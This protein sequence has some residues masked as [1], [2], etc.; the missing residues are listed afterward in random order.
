MISQDHTQEFEAALET[1]SSVLPITSAKL[2][3]LHLRFGPTAAYY[4]AQAIIWLKTRVDK[5]GLESLKT[6]TE[7][8]IAE[9]A[10]YRYV[11]KHQEA[12]DRFED[13]IQSFYI[14]VSSNQ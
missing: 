12:L 14:E 2:R 4:A 7:E 8:E 10:Y 11:K 5:Q 1:L 3:T 6:V 13:V 9:F